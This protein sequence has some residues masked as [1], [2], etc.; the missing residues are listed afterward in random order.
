MKTSFII[1]WACLFIAGTIGELFITG[2]TGF[3]SDTM[4]LIRSVTRDVNIVN[5]T[6]LYAIPVIG[7]V[8][9]FFVMVGEYLALIIS[10]LF[11]WFPNI[12]AG[13]WIWVYYFLC[14]PVTIGF[15]FS[16]IVIVRGGS[17]S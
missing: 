7:Q 4:S 5:I 8:A 14:V 9:S 3:G 10:M 1:G 6:S 15:I 11:L 17:N 16:I 13:N 2:G 12:W